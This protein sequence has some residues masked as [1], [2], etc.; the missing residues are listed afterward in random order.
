MKFLGRG[1]W[2]SNHKSPQWVISFLLKKNGKTA[3]IW[4]E[5]EVI[6]ENRIENS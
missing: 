5:I 4:K 3:D 6:Q 1:G 2:N